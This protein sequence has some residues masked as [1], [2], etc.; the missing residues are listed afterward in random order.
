[1][2]DAFDPS[3]PKREVAVSGTQLIKIALAI[4]AGW[5][6]YKLGELLALAFLACLVAISLEPAIERLSRRM[7]RALAVVL[8]ASLLGGAF[9]GISAIV[10]PP[11]L[12]QAGR[13]LERAPAYVDRGLEKIASL[14]PIGRIGKKMIKEPPA[15]IKGALG[16]ALTVGQL[17]VGGATSAFL[18]YILAVYLMLDGPRAWKWFIAYGRP[19]TR[20]KLERSARAV[21]PVVTAYVL[22][23]AITSAVCGIFV[24]ASLK[25]LGVPAAMLLAALAAAFDVL[26]VLGFILSVVP[27]M[28]FAFTVSP[29]APFI[30][31]GLYFAY[32]A[33][34]NYVLVPMVYGNRLRLSGLAVLASLLA[35]G[36]LWGVLGAVSILPVIASFPALERIWLTAWVGRET[37]SQHAHMQP[38]A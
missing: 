33:L 22:G 11:M 21:A 14:G 13:A 36:A 31:L 2:L 3:G 19:E 38:T 30:V 6:V 20:A 35:A 37:V 16:Q 23:Q 4:V 32:H 17:A 12:E 26:P 9:V 34:E 10:V 1:M 8:I 18:V 5:L 15:D 27:A 7:S 25:V 24:Y 29:T 28:L